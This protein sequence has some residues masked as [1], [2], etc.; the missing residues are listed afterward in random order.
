VGGASGFRKRKTC[1]VPTEQVCSGIG[2]AV[3]DCAF[4]LSHLATTT[5]L[6]EA[7]VTTA[8]RRLRR[9]G[10]A[11]LAATVTA[12]VAIL[13]TATSAFA[14]FGTVTNVIDPTN[15]ATTV[16]PGTSA[17]AVGDYDLNLTNG[18]N[19]GD[20]LLVSL[21]KAPGCG[22]T[23]GAVG[24][25]SA[26]TVT[27]SGPTAGT[28]GSGAASTDASA[29][30]KPT[31]TAALQSSAGACTTAG[32]KDQLL[33]TLTNSS[34]GSATDNLEIVVGGQK[35]NVGSAVTT[36][37][38]TESTVAN[39]TPVA[40]PVTVAT[41]A[42]TK[43]TI[44]ATTAATASTSAQNVSI[45]TIT[46]SDVGTAAIIA[47]P[48]YL[49]ASA[50]TFTTGVTPTVTGPTGSTYTVAGQ[51]TATL[52]ITAGGTA[53]PTTNNT[54]TISGLQLTVPAGNGI[55]TVTA[56][57]GGA[58]P[59]TTAIG[60]AVTALVVSAQ[61][62]IGGID[63]YASSAQLFNSKFSTLAL[64]PSSV[65]LASGGN[66]PDA[67]SATYLAATLGTGVV[68]T[69][70][71]VLP[72]TTSQ[73]LTNGNITTVYIV[74]GTAA[75]SAAEQAAISSLHTGNAPLGPLLTVLR[76]AGA[77][78]YSTNNAADLFSGASAA[79]T[80]AI[81]AT[82]TNFAD[83][84][85]AGPASY[86]GN[87]V[88]GGK[89]FPLILT[90][91]T[92]LSASAQSSIVNLGIRNVVIVGGT[93]AVSAAV[94]TAIKALPGVTISYRIAGADRTQT[95][96]QIATWETQGLAATSTYGAL[97]SLGFTRS[98]SATAYIA[99]GDGFADA[100]SAGAVA[101]ANLRVI[102]L[103][104]DPNTLGAGIPSYL[105]AATFTNVGGLIAVGLTSAVSNATFSAAVASL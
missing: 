104:G 45:G 59:G 91:G 28:F 3:Q 51:G 92:T 60:A 41:V 99:R 67:L 30:A 27:A 47:S 64:H 33:I 50:G 40:A 93:S 87:T 5:S 26:P 61:S 24:F 25:A 17:A 4:G 34:T 15:G 88:A 98:T 97:A 18:F 65:V 35:V 39:A 76:V 55:Y 66:F 58:S 13:A 77:D 2:G 101:G 8:T 95:A 36:G 49:T 86:A 46:L 32:V 105:G 80:T 54:F 56:K 9:G 12:G 63:R 71:N 100:L 43:A 19:I 23:N 70:P 38:I 52:T 79:S 42:N 89:P 96:A 78:R 7:R 82:G 29:T 53:F 85:A 31:F 44:S 22:T 57:F 74:G 68:L 37:A 21:T 73:V 90:D 102:L 48:I 75:V 103:T 10:V 11:G 83:A 94:E 20:T 69:D 84:L 16:Y 14:A 62:R 72:Q 6:M 81:V 1:K